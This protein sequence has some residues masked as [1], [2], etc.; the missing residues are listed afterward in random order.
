[1]ARSNHVATVENEFER[2][3]HDRLLRAVFQ[4]IVSVESGLV[5]GYEG[6]IRG[7][8]GSILESPDALIKEA[9]RQN[10]VVEFDW[11]RAPRRAAPLLRPTWHRTTCCS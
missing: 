6:L 2:V 8:A 4:P 11:S 7:P 9:Y 10:R 5:V 3:L 1:M